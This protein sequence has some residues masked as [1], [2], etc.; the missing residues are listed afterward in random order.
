MNGNYIQREIIAVITKKIIVFAML[1]LSLILSA[2][3]EMVNE[4][5]ERF[6]KLSKEL[7]EIISQIEIIYAGNDSF[8]EALHASQDAWE[9]FQDMHIEMLFIG[10][11]K[12]SIYGSL[13]YKCIFDERSKLIQER[14]YQ[15]EQWLEGVP[16][17]DL[18]I[19]TRRMITN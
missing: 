16:E 9:Y 15:L 13:V 19:G 18:C 1:N 17:G 5:M 11:D 12:K 10:E 8:L 3:S 6:D 14:I 2:Q 4:S 7:T